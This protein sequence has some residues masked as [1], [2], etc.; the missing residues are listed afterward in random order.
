[1]RGG[2]WLSS[3][4]LVAAALSEGA[5]AHTGSSTP[6]VQSTFRSSALGPRDQG[7]RTNHM[8]LAYG[9]G[10]PEGAE[11]PGVGVQGMQGSG[12]LSPRGAEGPRTRGAE[13]L[14]SEQTEKQ[15]NLYLQQVD[16]SEVDYF[17]GHARE[18]RV[19]PRGLRLGWGHR[20]HGLR[21]L[22]PLSHPATQR[23]TPSRHPFHD[24]SADA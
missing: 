15:S 1:M 7:F 19:N 17:L 13:G 18:S 14:R 16:Y 24:A 20:A 4:A 8:L 3:A 21:S 2:R 6:W 23:S 10:G 22:V 11:S 12:G 5:E 9:R